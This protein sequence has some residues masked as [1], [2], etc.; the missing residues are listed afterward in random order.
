MKF[1][2]PTRAE[3]AVERMAAADAA[4]RPDEDCP[5]SDGLRAAPRLGDVNRLVPPPAAHT[6][7]VREGRAMVTDGP[8]AETKEVVGSYHVRAA[9]DLAVGIPA[10][11]F[12]CVQVRPIASD[13][14][15][16]RA[17][18]QDPASSSA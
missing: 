17:L 13:A 4:R 2:W 18:G 10:A 14:L 6:P 11:R 9:D 3:K 7:R 15:T 1:L 8:F 16:G 5:F 12:G